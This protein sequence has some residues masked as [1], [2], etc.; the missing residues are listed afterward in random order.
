MKKKKLFLLASLAATL[1][2]TSC[3]SFDEPAALDGDGMPLTRSGERT[4][5]FDVESEDDL[6]YAL[7]NNKS[8]IYIASSFDLTQSVTVNSVTTITS[9]SDAVITSTAPII[10]KANATFNGVKINATTPKGSGAINME[11]ENINVVLKNVHLTQNTAGTAD[12]QANVGIAIL[13]TAC[14]NTLTIDSTT[15]VLPGNYVRAVSMYNATKKTVGLEIK[16]SHITCG[17]DLSYPSTYARL[18]SFSNVDTADGSPVVVD[19]STLEGAYYVFNVNM[20]SKIAVDVKNNS[21]LDGR[22]A[23]NLWS[24][25]CTVNVNNSTLTGRNNYQGPTE[26]FANIVL[27]PGSTNSNITLDNVTFNLDVT[28]E[29]TTNRQYAISLRQNNQKI[30]LAGTITIND[31]Q[32]NQ[33][34]TYVSTSL[35]DLSDI[36]VY[37]E[38]GY[39]YVGN[40]NKASF[41]APATNNQ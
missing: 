33:A 4:N 21:V 38:T 20:D 23:F 19:N 15:M 12:A 40:L 27:N 32:K 28:K 26:S 2:M 31:T 39:N 14:K 11:A 6:I 16:N 34:P 7:D 10:C 5:A 36:N 41:F 1:A 8:A 18:L 3:S 24:P 29:G 37:Q 22:A 30:T 25:N 17:S 9:A 13:N 35:T